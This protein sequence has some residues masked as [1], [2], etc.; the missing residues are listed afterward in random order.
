MKRFGMN[1]L[2]QDNEK[3]LQ[4][5]RQIALENERKNPPKN[6]LDSHNMASE[7]TTDLAE[8]IRT[9]RPSLDAEAFVF[10]Q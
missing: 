3:V 10:A 6:R 1:D 8:L 5:R 4:L 9:M 7:G 2:T